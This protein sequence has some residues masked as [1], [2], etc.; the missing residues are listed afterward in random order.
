[1]TLNGALWF[2]DIH[3]DQQTGN[4]VSRKDNRRKLTE[5]FYYDNLG[6]LTQVNGP[7]PLTMSYSSNG[8]ISD[9]TSVGDYTYGSK[10]HAVIKVENTGGLISTTDQRITYTAFNKVDSIIQ[11]NYKYD[12]QYGYQDQRTVSK[13]MNGSG[14]V[15]KTRYY[16]GNY[17][18]ETEGSTT[19]EFYYIYGGDGLA[20]ILKRQSGT[21]TMYYIHKDHLGSFD[22]ITNSSGNVVDSSSFDAWGRRRNHANWTY[23][24]IPA[25]RFS[26]GYT[27]HEQLEQLGLINMN[28]R[29]YDPVLG[30]FLSVDPFIGNPYS[31]QEYNRYSYVV[32]NPLKYIDPTGYVSST[33]NSL[34][35]KYIQNKFISIAST[36]IDPHGNVIDAKR[37]GDPNI[38]I[39]YSNDDT[40]AYKSG[41]KSHLDIGGKTNDPNVFVHTKGMNILSPEGQSRISSHGG[42]YINTNHGMFIYL[43]IVPE[44]FANKSKPDNTNTDHEFL[45]EFQKYALSSAEVTGEIV[46]AAGAGSLEKAM[47]VGEY[48]SVPAAAVLLTNQAVKTMNDRSMNNRIQFGVD[49]AIFITCVMIA[50]PELGIV[51]VIAKVAIDGYLEK[52]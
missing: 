43:G 51:L 52:E 48:T 12:L 42:G 5:I 15:Q 41:D 2:E 39:S 33:N 34:V 26:R 40:E 32:N 47:K 11:S 37:D 18:K 3:F 9:K 13:L 28:G 29:M 6:R 14:T 35:D 10:P 36:L 4:L 19:R 17:E 23:T 1:M 50:Q 49:A 44:A 25:T 30:R 8:N 45:T 21:D 27:G 38:Y 22:I 20:A 7:A 46:K 31:S 24:N 16:F